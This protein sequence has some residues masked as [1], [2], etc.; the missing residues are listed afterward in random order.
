MFSK[1]AFPMRQGPSCAL[2]H[3]ADLQ[4]LVGQSRRCAQPVTWKHPGNQGEHHAPQQLPYR[5]HVPGN[6]FSQDI[7]M[8]LILL[9]VL[10]TAYVLE[11][12]SLVLDSGHSGGALMALQRLQLQEP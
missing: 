10:K 8:L 7:S 4:Q 12:S 5:R 11:S 1:R 6:S 2:T 9:H 3:P